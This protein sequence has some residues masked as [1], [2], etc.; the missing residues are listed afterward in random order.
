MK[1]KA[2]FLYM[3]FERP[4]GLFEMIRSTVKENVG[5]YLSELMEAEMSRFLGISRGT[6]LSTPNYI[7]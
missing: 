6:R 2:L 3:G 5:Q 7:R 4:D 1:R